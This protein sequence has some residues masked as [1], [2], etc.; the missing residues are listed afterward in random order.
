[1]KDASDPAMPVPPIRKRRKRRKSRL[2]IWLEYALFRGL[3]GAVHGMSETRLDRWSA[4]VGRLASRA[5]PSRNRVAMRNLRAAFP[6]RSERELRGIAADC[7]RHYARSILDYFRASREDADTITA[8]IRFEGPKDELFASIERDPALVLFAHYGN[9]EMATYLATLLDRRIT[10]VA[11]RLDNPLIDRDLLKNR[12]RGGLTILDRRKAARELMRALERREL[13]AMVVDQ[14]V[15]PREGILVPF[16]GR[17]AWTTTAPARLA[18]RYGVPI[19]C[20]H[21]VAENGV[22]DVAIDPP[23]RVPDDEDA[24]AAVA[25]TTA[26]IN[27]QFSRRIVAR[28]ELWLWMHDRWKGAPDESGVGSQESGVR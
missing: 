21:V 1:M 23:L 5:L 11:R 14:A 10:A 18:L 25:A 28:P 17:P 16:V 4:R 9:W 6:D 24:E 2:L 15:K 12:E 26:R 20:L 8:R 7:W 19:W 13:V 22:I 3:A 27:E